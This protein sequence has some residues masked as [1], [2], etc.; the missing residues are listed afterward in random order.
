MIGIISYPLA[1]ALLESSLVLI[2]LILLAVILPGKLLRDS[3]VAQGSLA[4][5]LATLGMVFAHLY[6]KGFGIWSVRGFGKYLLILVGIIFASW[7]LIY[8]V[9]KLKSVVES[10]A[11]RIS[12]LS[13]AYLALDLLAVITIIVRNI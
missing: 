6:G 7:I 8:Y 10:I 4:G 12:P 1:F 2:G 11:D 13:I 5:L 9:K 3:F